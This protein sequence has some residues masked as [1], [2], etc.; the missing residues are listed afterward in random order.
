[1]K[2]EKYT[3]QRALQPR[4]RRFIRQSGRKLKQAIAVF[5][6]I[7]V[8]GTIILLASV[9]NEQKDA[10]EDRAWNDIANLSGAFEE[11]IR[12]VMDSVRGAIALLKPRL[13]AEGAAFDFVEWTKRVPELATS[14]AQIAFVGPDGKLVASS[15][16]RDP[17]PIDLS[18]REHIRVQLDGAYRG[19]LIGKPVIGRISGQPTIQVTDRVENAEG[20]LIGIIVFSLAPEFLTTLQRAVNLGHTGTM[21][22]AGTDGVIRASFGAWQKTDIDHIGKSISGMKAIADAQAASAGAYRGVNPLNGE[23]AFFHWRKLK[24]DP[25]VVIVGVEEAEVFAV[26]NRS[27]E[28]LAG[29]GAG[30]LLLGLTTTMILN[31]E[32]SRRVQREI[33]LFDGSRKLVF[34]N[35]NLQRRHRQ[36]RATSAELNAE[37]MRLQRVN[38]EL[39]S[40]KEQADQASQA[41]TSLLMNMSH[42]FRTPMHA[43]LN[44]T[45]MCLKKMQASEPEK[46]KKYLT[47][48]Q[49]SGLRLLELLN[50]LLDLARL[51]SGKLELKLARGDLL[52]VIRQSQAELGSLL[53]AKQLEFRVHCRSAD[54]R[55]VFDKERLMQVFIN[56][57]SNAIKFSPKEGVIDL[58]IADSVLPERGPAFH[59]VFSDQGV[60]IPEAERET[61][62]EKFEQSSKTSGAGGSGLGLAICREIVHLHRGA[63]WAAAAPSGGAAIHV[64]IPK[65]AADLA[66]DALLAAAG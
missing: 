11:Q 16:T 44:Y 9:A 19:V 66:S 42:E 35:E 13:A 52:Q 61:I 22:L 21:I 10:A 17:K 57:L 36:L 54:P 12:R 59:C 4:N 39:K 2:Q 23:K 60:G 64:V 6:S 30:I 15:L 46:Q 14:T 29:L 8:L 32:I 55:G 43:I 1:M 63:I 28:I 49:I 50:A 5:A 18:D 7:T 58:T 3:V 38:V 62:F 41:K 24:D 47:N 53:E 65:E 51:E 20:R 33:A 40:A 45:N 56:L 27:A 34:A 25:L 37:R 31:R 26:T 48:I